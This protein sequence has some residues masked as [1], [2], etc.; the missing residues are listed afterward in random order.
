MLYISKLFASYFQFYIFSPNLTQPEIC[1]QNSHK[2]K[3]ELT[4]L[5]VTI[6]CA[7]SR[8]NHRP[9]VRNCQNII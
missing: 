4:I 2:Y 3:Y 9:S 1:L 5:F 8:Y 7:Q 6:L